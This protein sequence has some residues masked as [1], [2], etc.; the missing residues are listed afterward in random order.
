M[1]P[2]IPTIKLNDGNEIPTIA[3]GLG[4]AR[5][6]STAGPLD[7]AIVQ[8]TKTA[9]ELGYTHLDGAELY[10]NEEEQGEAVRASGVPREKL[11]IVTKHEGKKDRTLTESF[12]ESLKKLG[13]DYVDLYLLH[14]PFAAGSDEQN[15]KWWAEAEALKEAGRAK[16]I[17]VSNFLVEHLESLLKTAKVVPAVNQIEYHPYLQ[18]DG[19][20]DYHR[21]HGIAT[22][23]YSP[24]TPLT[25]SRGG[26]VDGILTELADKYNVTE[27]DV[28]LR[29]VLDQGL[30]VIT[31]SAKRERLQGYLDKL[32]TFKLTDKEIAEISELGKQRHY[33]VWW[34]HIFAADDRR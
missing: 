20:I 32:P 13:V 12:N 19:L 24:L 8:V 3:Y 15:Q 33:R 9:I 2:S 1:A 7:D 11:Y 16:S 21:K 18:H 4:T 29:W 23:V 28:G 34:T 25:S 26:P 6:K 14:S 10:G 30:I 5:Y 17:G 31:T 27:S 22:S